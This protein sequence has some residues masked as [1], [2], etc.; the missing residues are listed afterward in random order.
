MNKVFSLYIVYLFVF[1]AV[2]PC[3]AAEKRGKFLTDS[4]DGQAYMTMKIGNQV[5]MAENLNYEM[6]DSYCYDDR[7]SNCSKY[8][9]LY[10]WDAAMKACPLGW[11]LPT[12]NEWKTLFAMAGGENTAGYLLKSKKDWESKSWI[13]SGSDPFGFLVLPAGIRSDSGT[14]FSEHRYAAFWSSEDVVSSIAYNVQFNSDSM[15]VSLYVAMKKNGYSV[16]CVKGN[17]ERKKEN[18][19]EKPHSMTGSRNEMTDP[20]DGKTYRIVTIGEQVWMAENLNYKTEN[21]DC[22]GKKLGNCLKYGQHYTWDDAQ[23]ACPAGWHL[24]TLTEWNI[25]INA[26]GGL[27]VAGKVLKAQMGWSNGGDGT[28]DFGF[29]AFPAGRM[30]FDGDFFEGVKAFFWG[31]PEDGSDAVYY[32][33]L[34]VSDVAY[35]TY[36]IKDDKFSVRCIKDNEKG[37]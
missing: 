2:V 23:M 29:T 3:N 16:R 26:V 7:T 14:Y 30:D 33:G 27:S 37:N 24:P 9:R 18:K 8:G 1:A 28:N 11:H 15:N 21:S 31:A 6:A 20:R 12:Q 13:K 35:I 5:W 19:S 10:T 17:V 34:Q 32:M 4:R 22:F 36:D 25:L